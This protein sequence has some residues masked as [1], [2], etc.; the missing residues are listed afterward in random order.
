MSARVLNPAM[1]TEIGRNLGGARAAPSRAELARVRRD[2]FGPVDH[3]AARALAEKELKAQ[4][5]LDAERWGFDFRLE[6]PKD[7]ERYEWEVISSQ[8]VV[9]EPYALRGMPY[10]RKNAPGTPRKPSSPKS[11]HQEVKKF[12]ASTPIASFSEHAERTP[13]QDNRVPEIGETTLEITEVTTEITEICCEE[14]CTQAPHT[15]V[16][17]NSSRKQSTITGKT[18]FVYLFF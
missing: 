13:P 2:L 7:N 5:I 4:S 9:P 3:A 14:K 18:I 11:V 17:N 8:E 1:M 16:L 6:M 12:V 15:P 10:L